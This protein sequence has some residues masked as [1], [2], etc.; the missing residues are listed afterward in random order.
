MTPIYLVVALLTEDARKVLAENGATIT[1]LQE[2]HPHLE[3]VSMPRA[4]CHGR[5][6][7]KGYISYTLNPETGDGVCLW[8]QNAATCQLYR[9]SAQSEGMADFFLSTDGKIWPAGLSEEQ[10]TLRPQVAQLCAK[11]AQAHPIPATNAWA[12]QLDWLNEQASNLLRA[13]V[14]LLPDDVRVLIEQAIALHQAMETPAPEDM[15][16]GDIKHLVE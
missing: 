6:P 12:A 3:L 13:I 8:D 2:K 4:I 9:W 5:H 1:V 7:D 14:P 11:I 15:P 10:A 16:I